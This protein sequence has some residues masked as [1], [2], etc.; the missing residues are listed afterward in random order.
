M[1]AVIFDMDGVISDT[2]TLCGAAESDTLREW[3]ILMSPEEVTRRFAGVRAKEWMRTIFEEQGRSLEDVPRALDDRW[4]H[5]QKRV[6][7]D[8]IQEIPGAVMLIRSLAERPTPLAVA[9]SSRRA[10]IDRVLTSLR[11]TDC[12]QAIVSADDV[13]VGKPDPTIF[14]MAAQ[15]LDIPSTE[16]VVIEDSL[17]GMIAAKAAN[18]FCVGLLLQ[19]DERTYPADVIVHAHHEITT[20]LLGLS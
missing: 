1:K 20:Q 12:F 7:R 17:P 18:M 5:I 11:I 15:K 9:S 13:T 4:R 8:G 10:F 3:G 19:P 14:L 2:Q 6:E 16:C